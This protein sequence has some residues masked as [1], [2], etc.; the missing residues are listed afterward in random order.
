MA[1][2]NYR[3]TW[4][5]TN[6]P[7][8]KVPP[9]AVA[10]GRHY[11]LSSFTFAHYGR[12][13]HQLWQD[14]SLLPKAVSTRLHLPPQSHKTNEEAFPQTWT[15]KMRQRERE[16]L[17][18]ENKT[19][20]NQENC[21]RWINEIVMGN[22]FSPGRQAWRQCILWCD[23]RWCGECSP[24]PLMYFLLSQGAGQDKRILEKAG[25]KYWERGQGHSLQI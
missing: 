14:F 1:T 25:K 3:A 22:K 18:E 24:V 10:H 11:T 7:F 20:Q 17:E 16:R 13:T 23:D 4:I 8:L 12:T 9:R 15:L 19:E 6:C 2:N 21:V 5:S